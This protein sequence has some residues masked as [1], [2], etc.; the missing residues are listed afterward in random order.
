MAAKTDV[1]IPALEDAR[2]AHAAVVDRFRRG[3]TLTPPGTDR[4][5][6]ENQASEAQ[7]YLGRID[8]RMREMRPPRGPLSAAGQLM[9][10][11]TRGAVRVSVLPI[12]AGVSAVTEIV[13][14]KRPADEHRLLRA[15]EDE[16]TAAARAL[17]TCQAGKDIAERLND[18]ETAELLAILGRQ[19][20]VLL[21]TGEENLARRA[22]AVAVAAEGPRP[23]RGETVEGDSRLQ[24]IT[25]QVRAATARLRAL[26]QRVTGRMRGPDGG[27][28]R[29]MPA[30]TRVAEKVQGAMAREE[31]LPVPGYSRLG[32]TEIQQRLHGLSQTELTVIEGYERA[33][34]GRSGVLNAIRHLRQAEPWAGYD[35]MDPERIKMHLHDVPDDVARQVLEYERHHRQRDT[36][37]NAAEAVLQRTPEATHRTEDALR[38]VTRDKEP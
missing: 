4:Q 29:E 22:R 3:A 34:A 25:R 33:H 17:A 26:P 31:A 8:A 16:Y 14:G 24:A 20:E 15:A 36:L 10:M 5:R 30:A 27:A 6:L 37:I 35:A 38:A 28:W 1:L 7:Y 18:Q 9:R 12:Q 23:P 11:V 19:G 2:D 13:R 21:E 32:V